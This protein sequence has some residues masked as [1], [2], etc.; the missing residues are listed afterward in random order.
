MYRWSILLKNGV[1]LTDECDVSVSALDDVPER[2]MVGN[3]FVATS[4]VVVI[5]S[6]PINGDTD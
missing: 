2:L 5:Q 1:W 6:Q 4:E 3:T